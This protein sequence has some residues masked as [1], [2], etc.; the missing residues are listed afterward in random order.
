MAIGSDFQ[1][2]LKNLNE[3]KT[4]FAKEG[5][6]A[7]APDRDVPLKKAFYTALVKARG[8]RSAIRKAR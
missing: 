3:F 4:K 7:V 8:L 6:R 5:V 2:E 1:P